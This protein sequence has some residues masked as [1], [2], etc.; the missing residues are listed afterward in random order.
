MQRAQVQSLVRELRSHS[1]MSYPLRKKSINRR[2]DGSS[3]P[4]P[5]IAVPAV[6][7]TDGSKDEERDPE[8]STGLTQ[9][10]IHFISQN[11]SSSL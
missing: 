7:P 3:S 6:C 1:C 11:V 5:C 10:N 2:S 8:C 9:C 4:V